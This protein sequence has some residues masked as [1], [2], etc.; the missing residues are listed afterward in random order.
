MR[1]LFIIM[2]I[3]SGASFAA[4]PQVR[5][6]VDSNLAQ[7][8]GYVRVGGPPV[9]VVKDG[10]QLEPAKWLH[11]NTWNPDLSLNKMKTLVLQHIHLK[12]DAIKN[13]GSQSDSVLVPY[14]SE[15]YFQQR[16]DSVQL[17]G[18]NVGE[19][20]QGTLRFYGHLRTRVVAAQIAAVEISV[21]TYQMSNKAEG[22]FANATEHLNRYDQRFINDIAHSLITKLFERPEY[23]A[24]LKQVI[25]ARK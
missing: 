9:E 15:V 10:N 1:F 5:G 22:A 11:P 4:E 14:V 7:N 20:V 2:F 17:V 23:R 18:V 19:G 6:E 21:E 13:E 3:F 25:D 24:Q 8:R 12:A 16:H